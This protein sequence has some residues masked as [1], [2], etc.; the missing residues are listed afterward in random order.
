MKDNNLKPRLY[1]IECPYQLTV[2][3]NNRKPAIFCF[4]QQPDEDKETKAKHVGH[5]FINCAEY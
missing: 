5:H 1:R 4:E 2:S 3:I